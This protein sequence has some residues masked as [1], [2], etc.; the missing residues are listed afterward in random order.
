[1]SSAP[2]G[3]GRPA[4]RR[5]AV[6]TSA[7]AWRTSSGSSNEPAQPRERVAHAR[8]AE[9]HALRRAGDAALAEQRVERDEE[10]EV[11]AAEVHSL[12]MNIA[13]HEIQLSHDALA[14]LASRHD[15]E[16]IPVLIV[17]GS[18]VGLT[19]ALLLG[20]H[21]VP[22]LSVERHAGTA[23][24][25]RAG[26]FQLRTMEMLRQL[27]LEDA[28]A[29]RR[30]ET[31]NPTAASTRSSRSPAASS[32]AT[33]PTSTRGSRGSARRDRLF[34]DQDA[35]EPLLRE[36]AL[37]LGATAAQPRRGGRRSSR[38]PTASPSRCATSTPATERTVRARY[39]VAA[40]GNRSP[41]RDAA[42][43]RDG[44]LR[45]ALAQRHDLLPRRLRGRCCRTATRASS[46][47][48]TRRCAG[49]SGWTAA[50]ASGFLVVNT[51]RRGRDDR[52]RRSNVVDG[53]DEARARELLATAIGSR[54]CRWRSSTSRT[55]RPRPT[56]PTRLADGT[57]LPRRRRGAR[58]PAQRRLRRQ[59][60]RPGR[61]QPR[62]EARGRRR[63]ATPARRCST[64]T[65]PSAG[66]SGS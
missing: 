39:V 50:A 44:G 32:R 8:L 11:D 45:P 25:P 1:M 12:T 2:R 7:G 34:L 22:S 43:H 9:A 58:R 3:P 35:L 38:T 49:S 59:H 15:D 6:G 61:A 16:E 55:G 20:H 65:R 47:S 26:H 41:T 54:T 21:G 60:R 36:R 24:H 27:G 46:T 48:T 57:R 64:P 4:P 10:V 52:T 66:R 31:Y 23:I 29:R 63:R 37:E 33:S 53:M 5:A 40:D 30:C 56:W 19:T 18:L 42:R 28:C 14:G 51:R 17:G 62:V 13:H